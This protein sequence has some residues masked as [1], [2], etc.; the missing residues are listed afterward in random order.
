MLHGS[1]IKLSNVSFWEI[2]SWTAGLC[3]E[4]PSKMRKKI[5]EK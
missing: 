5:E 3:E 4:D 1:N 2:T